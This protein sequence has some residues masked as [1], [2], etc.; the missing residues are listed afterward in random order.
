MRLTT[1]ELTDQNE[2]MH[3][4]IH[5]TKTPYQNEAMHDEIHSPKTQIT[6]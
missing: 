3:D 1:Q 6:K 4:E 5:F 2:A